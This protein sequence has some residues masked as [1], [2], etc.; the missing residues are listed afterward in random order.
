[1][2]AISCLSPAPLAAGGVL[3]KLG[4]DNSRAWGVWMGPQEL[5]PASRLACLLPG[6]VRFLHPLQS[7]CLGLS[8]WRPIVIE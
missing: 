7:A 4:F 5:L 8:A 3:P 2:G 6:A 1:M